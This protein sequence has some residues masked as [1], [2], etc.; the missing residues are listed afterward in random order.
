MLKNCVLL[1]HLLIVSV[2]SDEY[3]LLIIRDPE[4][5]AS[6]YENHSSASVMKIIH[7]RLR[8]DA[9]DVKKRERMH[10]NLRAHSSDAL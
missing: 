2:K 5:I 6:R 3:F 4:Y 1:L 8:A 7:L 9:R 10:A